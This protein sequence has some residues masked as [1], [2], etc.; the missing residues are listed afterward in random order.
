MV[1]TRKG[2]GSVWRTGEDNRL[3]AQTYCCR[4]RAYKVRRC[5][6]QAARLGK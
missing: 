4:M 3:Q 6:L 2:I 5:E 1:G